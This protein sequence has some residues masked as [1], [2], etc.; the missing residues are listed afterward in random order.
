[1]KNLPIFCLIIAL[2]YTHAILADDEGDT[3]VQV[4][5]EAHFV[6]KAGYQYSYFDAPDNYGTIEVK[7][8]KTTSLFFGQLTSN[9]QVA[10]MKVSL[11]KHFLSHLKEA[12]DQNTLCYVVL[13]KG[14]SP[15]S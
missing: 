10:S 12:M 15:S 6:D 8:P 4:N 9:G 14:T 3:F 5:H 1:M 13:M 2:F 7:A 11:T